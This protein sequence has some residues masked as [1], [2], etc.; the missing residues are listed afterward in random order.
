MTTYPIEVPPLKF[1]TGNDPKRVR[2]FDEDMRTAERVKQ[3]INCR[4]E[5]DFKDCHSGMMTFG[6]I[7]AT[8]NLKEKTVQNYLYKFSGSS[9]KSIVVEHPKKGDG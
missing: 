6:G 8:L 1:Y 5:T 2:K 7:A 4:M 9:H 3:Y